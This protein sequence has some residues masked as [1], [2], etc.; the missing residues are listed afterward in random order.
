MS[1]QGD[2]SGQELNGGG[3]NASDN[4]TTPLLEGE[5][6][7]QQQSP[8]LQERPVIITSVETSGAPSAAPATAAPVSP[9]AVS[10][11]SKQE[12]P[13]SQTVAN[14]YRFVHLRIPPKE[15]KLKFLLPILLLKFQLVFIILFGLFAEYNVN[16]TY[17]QSKYPRKLQWANK[18]N[19]CQLTR[20]LSYLKCL[21]TCMRSPF[22]VSVS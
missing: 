12:R 16:E 11:S 7:K 17:S 9:S 22:L 18:R 2:V 10:P 15:G 1:N 14:E 5:N 8:V 13:L 4:A 3:V 21:L 6:N 20:L 19:R